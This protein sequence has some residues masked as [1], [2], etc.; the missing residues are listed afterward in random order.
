[1]RLVIPGNPIAKAR[2]KYKKSSS[3]MKASNEEIV[4]AYEE[5]QS[6][7]KV[8]KFLGMCPQSIHE[9]LSRL[10]L[11]NKMNVFTVEEK[12]QIL[13]VYKKGFK[14]GDGILDA[15]SR[16]LKRSKTCICRFAKKIGATNIKRIKTLNLCKEMRLRVKKWWKNASLDQKI[17][18]SDKHVKTQRKNGNYDRKHGS[19][20]QDWR[21][22]GGKTKFF[23]SRWE[24]N[25]ARYLEFLKQNGKIL[26][27]LHEPETFWFLE[28]KRGSRSY[29]PD[30]KVINIDGSHYWVEVKGW[31][32]DRSK[33]KLKRF[34]KYYP[35]EKLELI[36]ANWFKK[37]NDMMKNIVPE[38]E[39][40]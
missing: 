7:Q 19:W 22:I 1:M 20:K 16:K 29:L 18:R 27:W 11:N 21:T 39:C 8:A 35:Q 26:D 3:M 12:E 32:D 38:W 5:L 31:M 25:Y 30:F 9:R 37:N 34:A 14:S 33:T 17:Q 40:F 15:L 6:C 24:A 4:K 10:G 36:R 23:R 2:P 28:I 13:Q